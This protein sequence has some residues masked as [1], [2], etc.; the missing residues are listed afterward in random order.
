MTTKTQAAKTKIITGTPTAIPMK[1]NE[2]LALASAQ[3]Q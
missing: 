3:H 1:F 2:P